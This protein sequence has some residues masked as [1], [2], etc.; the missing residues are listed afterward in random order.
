MKVTHYTHTN[1]DLTHMAGPMTSHIWLDQLVLIFL[2]PLPF[3][4]S[5][6][7]SCIALAVSLF[8]TFFYFIL[9]IAKVH[10]RIMK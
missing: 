9:F 1:N 2:S 4:A 6:V 7:F 3:S 5:V 8:S 10:K